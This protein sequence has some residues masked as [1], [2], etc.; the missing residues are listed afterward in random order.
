MD[1][2][3]TKN[4]NLQLL[5]S[6][7]SV[8]Y[9]GN[10]DNI[11]LGLEY[12][13]LE[14]LAHN[15]NFYDEFLSDDENKGLDVSRFHTGGSSDGGLDGILF[16]NDLT[17]VAIIQTKNKKGQMDATTLGE[18][19][20]FF[21]R[22]P[23]WMNASNRDAW[24][25]NTKRLIDEAE[26]DPKQQ[27]ISLFF[28]TT[29]TRNDGI[30]Y[31]NI[32]DESNYS[33]S[34]KNWKVNCVLL[35][36]SDI[37]DLH[38]ETSNVKD[39]TLVSE[40]K[41]KVSN[42]YKF[43]FEDGEYKT[44]VTAIKGNEIAALYNRTGVKNKLFNLNV[45][46]AL[47]STGKINKKII[48]TA[49]DENEASNFFYYNNGITAT[50]S[51]FTL[52]NSEVTANHLQVV[53]G[54]QTVAALAAA[55]KSKK[56]KND[57]YILMR[58]IETDKGKNKSVVADKITK[59]QNTQ[60]PVKV[61]D[62]YSNE[63]INKYLEQKIN[64]KSGKGAFPSIWY[65][66]KRGNIA[67]GTAGRKKIKLEDL[68]YLRYACLVDAPFTYKHQKDIWDGVENNKNFWNAMGINGESCDS[69]P[70]EEFAKVGWMIRSWFNFRATQKLIDR[71]DSNPERLYLGTLSR[72]MTA[73]SFCGME[74]LRKQ[75]KFS[76]YIDLMGSN[77]YCEDVEKKMI[78][79][80][81][82]VVKTEYQYKWE[83]KVA[84]PRLNMPQNEST[85][86]DLR[87]KLISEYKSED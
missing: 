32:V 55:A 33:Y 6:D 9:G 52:D 19:R 20:D 69:W 72:Y 56:L 57:V 30:L 74:F 49:S 44:L 87:E 24:N 71:N 43:T 53:N 21:S 84:N 27:E 63:L 7:C 16:N 59:Y 79:V 12:F 58:L 75:G 39:S 17:N 25:E 1:S 50:C 2:S 78:K 23:E 67:K 22:L 76:S 34:V 41:F 3:K 29:M 73:L 64:E 13:S 68:A 18:A 61:S 86:D 10:K 31:E 45:R 46:A 4:Q 47:S 51:E 15:Q 38:K 60:N 28:I 14:L 77:Q 5:L 54:A 35:T 66:F 26:L 62:F 70:D 11:A 83:G 37:L 40:L 65:E 80:T 48:E 8:K 85:W 81:R 82:R 42:K 36:Q